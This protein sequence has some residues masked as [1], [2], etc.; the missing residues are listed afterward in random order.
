MIELRQIK[1]QH[2]RRRI[3]PRTSTASCRSRR[4]RVGD[5]RRRCSVCAD[6]LNLQKSFLNA[7]D[8]S[9][10]EE[11]EIRLPKNF[12]KTVV[13]NAESR[14]SGLR[15]PHEVRKRGVD[16]RGTHIVFDPHAWQQIPSGH[17]SR[18]RLPLRKSSRLLSRSDTLSTTWHWFFD[19]PQVAD[20]KLFC[21]IRRLG[22]GIPS[23]YSYCRFIC[24]RGS[25]GCAELRSSRD[26]E[27]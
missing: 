8:S 19:R 21:R 12:T 14:V 26:S 27:K 1:R 2:A 5:A 9:L 15:H 10:D 6:D 24:F 11:T 23:S 25:Y 3:F 4:A 18:L 7:L 22:S 17:C 16:L 20:F 13:A